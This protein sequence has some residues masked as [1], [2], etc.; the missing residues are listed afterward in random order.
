MLFA[1]FREKLQS[2]AGFQCMFCIL[3]LVS[4]GILP[5]WTGQNIAKQY[6]HQ[7]SG[8]CIYI[9]I[10][11]KYAEYEHVTILHIPNRFAYFLTY[12]LHILQI[13]L[14]IFWHILHIYVKYAEYGPVYSAFF[15]SYFVSYSAYY[16]KY[17]NAYSAYFNADSTYSA[18]FMHILHIL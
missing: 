4:S 11:D 10:Y 1:E 16:F 12:F 6:V 13:I 8:E 9:Y 3:C 5:L 14:H 17:F 2:Q 15:L 7:Q 18:F